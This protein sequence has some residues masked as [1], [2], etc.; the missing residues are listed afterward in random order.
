MVFDLTDKVAIVTGG[1]RGIGRAIALAYADAGAQLVLASRKQEG[2][3]AAAD[4]IRQRGG[5]AL[6]VATHMGQADDVA[7]LVEKAV[8]AF[9]GIDI[10]V[11][12]AATN[13]HF[14]PILTASSSQW[15]KIHE[16]NLKGAFLLA[17]QVAPHM[18]ARGGGSLLMVA[19]LAGLRPSTGMGVYSVFKAGLIM[20]TQVLA[21]ELAPDGIRVNALAPGVIRTRFSSALWETPEVAESIAAA[22]P[23]GRLGEVD[24]V[25]GAALYLA[26]PLSA[27]VTG[28]VLVIDGGLN[29]AGG[30]G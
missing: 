29:L 21:R 14:G 20:L 28:E 12:N 5:R 22:T 16:V 2:V 6:A 26:S 23:M 27:F 19:S 18:K 4:E 10:A 25:V 30:I 24:D 1:S 8:E 9:G 13:P 15:D 3:D 17:Q 11:S 7:S